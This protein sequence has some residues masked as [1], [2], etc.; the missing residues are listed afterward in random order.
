MPVTVRTFAADTTPSELIFQLAID[1]LLHV[2]RSA[3]GW[4]S[5]EVRLPWTT[6][7][8]VVSGTIRSNLYEAISNQS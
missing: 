4:A 8:I 6:D 5:E 2:R 1:R 7:T 3:Q